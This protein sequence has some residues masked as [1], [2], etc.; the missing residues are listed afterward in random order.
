VR[1]SQEEGI[2]EAGTKSRGEVRDRMHV[3]WIRRKEE[4]GCLMNVTKIDTI[5]RGE[6]GNGVLVL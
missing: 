3:H 5:D 2:E 4:G 6:S 1:L